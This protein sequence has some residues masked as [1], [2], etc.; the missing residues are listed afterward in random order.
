V[1]IWEAF[2]Q[3]PERVQMRIIGALLIL[4]LAIITAVVLDRQ[5]ASDI[6][7]LLVTVAAIIGGGWSVSRKI[8]LH[9]DNNTDQ[10]H[11]EQETHQK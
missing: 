5:A 6:T 4:L 7:G 10:Q 11:V 8:R 2:K 9:T 3:L 1:R